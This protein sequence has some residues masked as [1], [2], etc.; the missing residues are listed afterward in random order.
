MQLKFKKLHP[1]A[2]I[3]TKGTKDS[4]AVDMYAIEDKVIPLHCF[5]QVRTGLAVEIPEGYFGFI[6]PRSG[7]ATKEG[8]ILRSSN[9]VDGDFRGEILIC[10]YNLADEYIGSEHWTARRTNAETL[11][12]IKKGERIAQMVIIPILNAEPTEAK[13]LSTT[14]RGEAGFGSTG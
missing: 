9:V 8:L 3:P 14:E 12:Q 4:A 6:A 1:D 13:E 7:K 2:I 11:L 10:C 5:R